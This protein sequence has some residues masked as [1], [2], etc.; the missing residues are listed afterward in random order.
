MSKKKIITKKV[1]KG[2]FYHFH[3]GSPSG[4]PGMVYWKNDNKNLYLAVTTDSSPGEHRTKLAYPTS[5]NVSKSY[6]YNRPLLAK[7]KNI[8][9]KE[10]ACG[11][12]KRINSKLKLLAKDILERLLILIDEIEDILENLKRNQ[13]IKKSLFLGHLSSYTAYRDK[14]IKTKINK[15][16]NNK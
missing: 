10:M 6:V 3:E 9:G 15:L 4:H 12:I 11:L 7:R 14:P 13:N 2:K 1:K 16:I 8:G 5:S